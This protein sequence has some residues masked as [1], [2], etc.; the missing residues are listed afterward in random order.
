MEFRT[1]IWFWLNSTVD[2]TKT[3][4]IIS[5]SKQLR[6][7]FDIETKNTF[8]MFKYRNLTLAITYAVKFSMSLNLIVFLFFWAYSFFFLVLLA[9]NGKMVIS[10]CTNWKSSLNMTSCFKIFSFILNSFVAREKSF[11][12][13]NT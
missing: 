7:I 6:K 10:L 3:F 13:M 4:S 11:K 9:K 2:T 8:F 12:T 5:I 1:S